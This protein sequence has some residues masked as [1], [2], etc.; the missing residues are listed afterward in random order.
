MNITVVS[1]SFTGN[2]R[3]LATSVARE[4]GARHIDLA[5]PQIKSMM[6]TAL[7]MLG[8][9]RVKPG[10]EAMEGCDLVLFVAPVWM[11]H[12]S[13]PLR[14]YLSHLKKLPRRYGFLSVSGGG[15]AGGNVNLAAELERRA[16]A[17]PAV[18]V[19]L[20]LT[21]FLPAAK[22]KAEKADVIVYKVNEADVAQLTDAALKQIREIL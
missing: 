9:P 16:G 22:D 13:A 2:N 17:K 12:V 21:P 8:A 6:S 3:A 10:P 5:C 4:L 19:D 1:Y 14:T 11:G 20:P 7:S 15:A 18:V